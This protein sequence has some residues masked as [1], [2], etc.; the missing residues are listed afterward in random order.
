MLSFQPCNVWC[1]GLLNNGDIAQGTREGYQGGFGS[2]N[3]SAPQAGLMALLSKGIVGGEMAWPL[4]IAGML[5]GVGFIM[6]QVKSPMLV[7]VGLYL[8][9]Q[10]TFAIFIG[11][12]LKG[13]VDMYVERKNFSES[14]KIAT[15]NIGILLASGLNCR[16]GINGL[17]FGWVQRF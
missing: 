17:G 5:L 15:E 12:I 16:R 3:L 4:I 10:T 9:L 14:R 11:G 6:M 2:K 13:A 7:C 1:F 8:P